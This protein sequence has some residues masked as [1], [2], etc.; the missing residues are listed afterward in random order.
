MHRNPPDLSVVL[1][2]NVVLAQVQFRSHLRLFMNCEFWITEW[3]VKEK[4]VL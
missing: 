2:I 4:T 3:V 1:H